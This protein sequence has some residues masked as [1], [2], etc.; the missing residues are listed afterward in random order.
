MKVGGK[1]IV[2]VPDLAYACKRVLGLAPVQI[3]QPADWPKPY[4]HH[5]IYG[6][7]VGN[8][9][10]HQNGFTA[11]SLETMARGL[12]PAATITLEH[13]N[14]DN[15]GEMTELTLTIVKDKNKV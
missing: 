10:T 15:A 1:L 2:R 6:L 12:F 4:H 9:Q 14:P 3:D 7:Q 8:G 11:E 13:T 5:M